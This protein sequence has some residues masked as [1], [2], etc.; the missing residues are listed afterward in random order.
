[1]SLDVRAEG[2]KQILRI[3]NYNPKLSL[4]K[5]TSR[6]STSVTQLDSISG[7]QEAFEAVQE[8]VSFTLAI[9]IDFEGIGLSLINRKAV[10]VVY[11][12]VNGLKFEYTNSPVAQAVNLTCGS[13]QIDNQLHDALFPVVLQP[14][15]VP[16][17]ATS[18]ASLPTL[19]GSV[20]W[21]KDEGKHIYHS[22]SQC[23]HVLCQHSSWCHL[24]QVLLY[25]GA[26]ANCAS[27]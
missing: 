3:S 19:Q 26:S 23:T 20:I 15:P 11:L 4:Y 12:S 2:L 18:V 6:Q 8:E 22:T 24:R 27:R 7:S 14:T 9:N 17:D 21:L 13:L 25:L 16:K 1:M 5:P 10:E